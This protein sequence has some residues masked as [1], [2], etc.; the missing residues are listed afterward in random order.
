MKTTIF[1]LG[2]EYLFDAVY[3]AFCENNFT[4]NFWVEEKNVEGASKVAL[5][6]DRFLICFPRHLLW[7]KTQRQSLVL[8]KKK[9][10]IEVQWEM[11]EGGSKICFIDQQLQKNL[12]PCIRTLSIF[13]VS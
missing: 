8:K 13:T 9:E 1:S 12:F 11:R 2:V 5:T 7:V 4:M 6:G 3:W 10:K